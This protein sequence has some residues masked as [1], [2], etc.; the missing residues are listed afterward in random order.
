MP[1]RAWHEVD[2]GSPGIA[3]ADEQGGREVGE[4]VEEA[5]AG[6][7][8]GA[9]EGPKAAGIEARARDEQVEAAVVG[10]A[11]VMRDFTQLMHGCAPGAGA[12]G[13][14]ELGHGGHGLALQQL[15]QSFG[16][17]LGGLMVS[18]WRL[19]VL[20]CAITIEGDPRDQ[21]P[22][23]AGISAMRQRRLRLP[24]SPRHRPRR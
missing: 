6:E 23:K 7:E 17:V 16:G 4:G 8:A 22:S 20:H 24:R 13:V 11:G 2:E 9:A 15:D 3:L 10:V 21:G 5:A 18:Q 1:R 19:G 14:H 12:E